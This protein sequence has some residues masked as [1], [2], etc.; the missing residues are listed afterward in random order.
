MGALP[1]G[2][3]EKYAD[4]TRDLDDPSSRVFEDSTRVKTTSTAQGL[5]QALAARQT[6]EEALLSGTTAI[7]DSGATGHYLSR[8][9]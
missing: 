7:V 4:M 3:R 8:R 2:G 1:R 5:Q 9:V 6:L